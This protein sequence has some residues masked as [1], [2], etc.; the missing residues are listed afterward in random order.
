MA[1]DATERAVSAHYTRADMTEL[2]AAALRAA[3]KDLDRLTPDDLIPLDQF[4]SF[5]LAST[6]ELARRAAVAAGERVLDVGGG[7]GGP[8]RFLASRHECHVTV[9]DLTPAFVAAG[10]ALTAWTRLSDRV[11]FVCAS[12]LEMPFPDASFDLAWIQNSAM[13]IADKPRFYGEIARV[14]R[15]GGRLAFFG[16]TAGPNGPPHFPVPWANDPAYSF[17]LPPEEVRQIILAAGCRERSWLMGSELVALLESLVRE[18]PP[19]LVPRPGLATARLMRDEAEAKIAN[20][21]RNTREG[22]TAP[23][24]GVFERV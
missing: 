20:S 12:A 19:A 15:P 3:G 11:S 16:V 1:D 4:H 23:A 6:L 21:A 14:L 22:R 17:L 7:I 8:A 2:I 10:E 13:N 9:L 24:M 18:L 5:G